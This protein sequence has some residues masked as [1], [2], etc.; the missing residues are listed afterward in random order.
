MNGSSPTSQNTE[1]AKS[2]ISRRAIERQGLDELRCCLKRKIFSDVVSIRFHGWVIACRAWGN[3]R[4]DD[5]RGRLPTFERGKSLAQVLDLMFHFFTV[6]MD[7]SQFLR[8]VFLAQADR[9]QFLFALDQVID[10]FSHAI[11]FYQL[12]GDFVEAF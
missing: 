8:Q 5:W 10:A 2:R 3:H 6:L 12:S 4:H 11:L 9:L 1:N 7:S